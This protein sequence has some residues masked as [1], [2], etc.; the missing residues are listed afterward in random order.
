VAECLTKCPNRWFTWQQPDILKV[1]DAA[2][3]TLNLL[4]PDCVGITSLTSL[5]GVEERA[6]L[7]VDPSAPVG[8][9]SA[10][11]VVRPINEPRTR[12]SCFAVEPLARMRESPSGGIERVR[13]ATRAC[14]LAAVTLISASQEGRPPCTHAWKGAAQPGPSS[15]LELGERT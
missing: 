8:R 6:T 11:T 5:V 10:P 15:R 13:W 12:L 3:A 4:N 2:N 14:D 9:A 1:S 7:E